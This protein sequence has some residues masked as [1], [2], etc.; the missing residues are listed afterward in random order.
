MSHNHLDSTK[1]SKH[2]A[3]AHF[4]AT[5]DTAQNYLEP[6]L[7]SHIHTWQIV[8]ELLKIVTHEVILSQRTNCK[9]NKAPAAAFA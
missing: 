3:G 6:I 8:K 5:T 1:H 2:G 9:E 4:G 7:F